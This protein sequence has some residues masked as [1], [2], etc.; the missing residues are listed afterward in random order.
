MTTEEK[1][2][3]ESMF[4]QVNHRFDQVEDRL[5][6]IDTRLDSLENRM[7]SLEQTVEEIKEDT[8]ITRAAVNELGNWAENVGVVTKVPYPLHLAAE[9]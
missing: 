2:F 8:V 9:P 1:L 6:A 3:F 5:T 4:G 7:D